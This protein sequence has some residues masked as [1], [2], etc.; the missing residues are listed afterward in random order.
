M[1]KSNAVAIVNVQASRVQKQLRELRDTLTEAFEAIDIVEVEDAKKLKKFARESIKKN[2]DT[3]LVVGG[4]GTILTILKEADDLDYKKPIGIIPLGTS[5][6]LARNMGFDLSIK[7]AIERVKK[8]K[9]TELYLP[10]ANGNYFTLMLT[11]G[12]TT[13]VS[14]NIEV[15]FKQRFGQ[16]AY[17]F[18]AFRQLTKKDAFT[19]EVTVDGEKTYKGIT[20]QIVVANADLN[21][22]LQVVPGSKMN[23]QWLRLSIYEDNDSKLRLLFML[24]GYVF[25]LGRYKKGLRSIKA[26]TIDIKT[27]PTQSS[28]VDGEPVTS[29][30]L[31]VK[32]H[33]TSVR[34]YT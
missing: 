13:A 15:K 34:L 33:D 28:A 14:E 22:Q 20:H 29:T 23:E 1:K 21:T 12:L 7:D 25:T 8:G 11:I 32:I 16:F 2:P 27:T 6:Y 17:V 26:K 19:Y 30:P 31:S 18:E 9:T 24:I 3:L 10:E 4:D 5:N